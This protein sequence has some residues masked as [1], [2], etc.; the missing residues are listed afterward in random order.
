MPPSLPATLLG[1]AAHGV[2]GEVAVTRNP[3]GDL[4]VRLAHKRRDVESAQALHYR[5]FYRE[6]GAAA[7]CSAARRANRKSHARNTGPEI[8]LWQVPH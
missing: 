4:I 3:N 2:R 5:V 7:L 6:M 1:G 8:S